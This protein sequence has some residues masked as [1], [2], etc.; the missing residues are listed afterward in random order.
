MRQVIIVLDAT[1][2]LSN[3]QLNSKWWDGLIAATAGWNARVV[4]PR[5]VIAETV[6]NFRRNVT[7]LLPALSEWGKKENRFGVAPIRDA[8]AK[9]VLALADDFEGTLS[10]ALI[11]SGVSIVEP[12]SNQGVADHSTVA[13]RVAE[14][15]KPADGAARKDG[16]RDTLNWLT[17]LDLADA[18]PGM[19]ILWI[20][21]NTEDFGAATQA[22]KDRPTWH[23]EILAEL[24]HRGLADRVK[25]Y[26]NI[27]TLLQQVAA[28][29]QPVVDDEHSSPIDRM[30]LQD[31]A[32]RGAI[33]AI[34]RS[35]K[36]RAVALPKIARRASIIQIQELQNVE[37]SAGGTLQSGEVVVSFVGSSVVVLEFAI[38]A[39][40]GDTLHSVKKTLEISGVA[41]LAEDGT[42][43]AVSIT[44]IVA[45]KD[46]PGH[47]DWKEGATSSARAGWLSAHTVAKIQGLVP[48]MD[49][50]QLLRTMRSLVEMS[51]ETLSNVE[52]SIASLTPEQLSSIQ[53]SIPNFDPSMLANLADTFRAPDSELLSPETLAKVTEL[54]NVDKRFLDDIANAVGGSNFTVSFEDE[55]DDD[56]D[57]DIGEDGSS[58]ADTE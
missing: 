35:V 10:A 55:T 36:P 19:D 13:R 18:H 33:A 52:K 42:L 28:T 38:N 46:D 17:V 15:R 27:P 43:T 21:H 1:V 40:A 26:L 22:D 58:P 50:E 37:V 54:A 25:W 51:P 44:D 3:P 9:S 29:T 8:A 39:L 45:P 7:G 53:G 32:H 49:D 20:S 34:G 4:V 14:H 47:E 5:V 41:T 2:L 48:T 56:A 12:P 57:E 11:A 23:E 31:L 6:A 24:N 30:S 16:Y